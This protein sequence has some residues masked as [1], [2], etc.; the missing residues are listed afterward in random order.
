MTEIDVTFV[1]DNNQVIGSGP[2]RESWDKGIAVRIARVFIF[3]KQGELLIQ[4][5]ADHLESM[6]GRWDSSAS[7]HVDAGESYDEAA[8]RELKEETGLKDAELE[9]KGEFYSSEIDEPDK[10][11]KRFTKIYTGHYDGEISADGEDVSEMRWVDPNELET[12]MSEKPKDFTEG[13]LKS[14]KYLQSNR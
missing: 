12:W 8:K 9:P 2:K 10:I 3:N 5:R 11:K 14:F 6:P 1:D 4:K 7:G 13:F